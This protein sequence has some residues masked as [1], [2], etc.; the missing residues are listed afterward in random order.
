MG[1]ANLGKGGGKIRGVMGLGG[2]VWLIVVCDEVLR[3]GWGG[4]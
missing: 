1:W 4:E 3:V 2:M